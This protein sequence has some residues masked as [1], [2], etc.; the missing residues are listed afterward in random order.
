MPIANEGY[1]C[2][3]PDVHILSDML[4]T[5][6]RCV[7][8]GGG[9][10]EGSAVTSSAGGAGCGSGALTTW[11]VEGRIIG[12]RSWMNGRRDAMVLAPSLWRRCCSLPVSNC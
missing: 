1:R 7:T 12:S 6:S 2:Y 3:S 11:T 5:A 9:G 10:N 4:T 8:P